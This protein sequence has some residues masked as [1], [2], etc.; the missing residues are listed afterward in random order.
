MN[1]IGHRVLFEMQNDQ[2]KLIRG[3]RQPVFLPWPV[4]AAPENDKVI[5]I[6]TASDLN[7]W[8]P[9]DVQVFREARAPLRLVRPGTM[10]QKELM[11]LPPTVGLYWIDCW[12]CDEEARKP[13]LDT[14]LTHLW[15]CENDYV[16]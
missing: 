10:T 4:N 12:V 6:A 1:F 5:F 14:I 9:M 8:R 3:S 15:P 13:L 7:F 2:R 11:A 16:I